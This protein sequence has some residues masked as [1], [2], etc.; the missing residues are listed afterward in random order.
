MSVKRRIRKFSL[1][2]K[3]KIDR[4]QGYIYSTGILGS[5]A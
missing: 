5:L 3:Q 1:N 4:Q 2:S